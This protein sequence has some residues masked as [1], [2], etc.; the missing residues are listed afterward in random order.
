IHTSVP[1]LDSRPYYGG[2]NNPTINAVLKF[3]LCDGNLSVFRF[4]NAMKSIITNNDI[5]GVNL[6]QS[7]VV[8]SRSV[9]IY[10]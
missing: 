6:D 2:F 8:F 9:L 1:G 4:R 7:F 3:W 5:L 10:D